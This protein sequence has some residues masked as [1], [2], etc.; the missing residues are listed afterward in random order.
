MKALKIIG[1]VLACVAGAMLFPYLLII[2]LLWSP[3]AWILGFI[4]PG[5]NFYPINKTWPIIN[6]WVGSKLGIDLNTILLLFFAFL[7][8]G[9]FISWIVGLFSNKK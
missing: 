2:L 1:M 9:A 6:D 7:T 8:L 5:K 4:F 3:V